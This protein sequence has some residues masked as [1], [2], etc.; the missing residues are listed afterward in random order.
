MPI[1]LFFLI[2]EAI[3]TYMIGSKIGFLNS[4]I[5]M[6]ISAILGIIILLNLKDVFAAT[7]ASMQLGEINIA[8]FA[9]LNFSALFG[10]ILI[11]IPGFLSDIIG[12]ILLT[13]FL[14]LSTIN[15]FGGKYSDKQEFKS[16][17]KGEDDVIDAEIIDDSY[18]ISR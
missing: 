8:R 1:L 17:K 13:I 18:A 4:I 5:E 6:V 2:L 3:V 10:A 15:S 12:F 9:S 16:Y 14:V 11:I 7:A